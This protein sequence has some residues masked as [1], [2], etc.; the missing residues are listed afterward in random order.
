MCG[1]VEIGCNI[2]EGF[3]SMITNQFDNLAQRIGEMASSG[4]QAVSTFWIKIDSLR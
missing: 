2:K 3:Q 4:L 1:K